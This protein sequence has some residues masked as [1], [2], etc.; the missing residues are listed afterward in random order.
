MAWKV[1]AMQCHKFLMEY[2]MCRRPGPRTRLGFVSS[3]L[4]A[5]SDHLDAFQYRIEFVL[6]C[7]EAYPMGSVE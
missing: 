4:A 1:E 2:S 6:T 7:P 5:L 3:G